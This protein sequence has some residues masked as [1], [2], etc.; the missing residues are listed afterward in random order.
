MKTFYVWCL[1]KGYVDEMYDTYIV[2][3]NLRFSHWLWQV[4]DIGGIDRAVNGLA[5]NSV[6]A[7]QWLWQVIDI[8]GIDQA[9]N[10]YRSALYCDRPMAMASHRYSR[11]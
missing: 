4:V 8:R 5:T 9:V 3:P 6:N 11:N 7:A 10:G 2:R 1:N